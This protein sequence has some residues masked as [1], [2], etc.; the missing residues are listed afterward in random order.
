MAAPRVHR[1]NALQAVMHRIQ[2]PSMS[3]SPTEELQRDLRQVI[4]DA[5]ELLKVTAG[6]AGEKFA[7]V[8]ARTQESLTIA[9]ARLAE[10]GGAAAARAQAAAQGTDAAVRANPWAAVGIGAAAGVLLG[11]L[12]GRRGS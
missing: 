12:L 10:L 5:E 11:L 2:E 3:H 7:D 4:H 8:R 6:Q 9:K 1:E